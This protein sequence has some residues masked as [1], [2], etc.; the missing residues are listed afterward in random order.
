MASVSSESSGGLQPHHGAWWKDRALCQALQGTPALALLYCYS[1]LQ[2][3]AGLAVHLRCVALPPALKTFRFTPLP[4]APPA[5]PLHPRPCIIVALSSPPSSKSMDGCLFSSRQPGKI[6]STFFPHFRSRSVFTWC[7]QTD[8][9]TA[10]TNDT[11]APPCCFAC[12]D[13]AL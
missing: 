12:L 6:K 4:P 9:H 10:L 11:T 1:H 8:S 5:C 3:P 2:L 7:L 13:L